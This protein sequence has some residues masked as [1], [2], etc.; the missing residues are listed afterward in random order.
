MTGL[1][2]FVFLVFRDFQSEFVPRV[3]SCRELLVELRQRVD[4]IRFL[5]TLSLINNWHTQQVDFVLAYP[6]AKVS[7]DVYMLPPIKW[8]RSMAPMTSNLSGFITTLTFFPQGI[9]LHTHTCMR[10]RTRTH[11]DAVLPR[12]LLKCNRLDRLKKDSCSTIND[13]HL[14]VFSTFCTRFY[15]AEKTTKHSF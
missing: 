15:G 1:V 7:H 9:H 6:Q 4:A 12:R 5:L 10:T 14:W 3:L 11:T 13:S 2:G 8:L